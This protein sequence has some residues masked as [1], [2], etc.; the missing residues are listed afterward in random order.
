MN[1]LNK[2]I[3]QDIDENY[4]YKGEYSEIDSIKTI[5]IPSHPAEN[6]NLMVLDESGAVPFLMKRVFVVNAEEGSIRGQHAHKRC[7][8]LLSCL[9][10]SI[11]VLCDDGKDLIEFTL[12]PFEKALLIPAGIWGVQKYIKKDSLLMVLC[13]QSYNEGDYIRDYSE[14]RQWKQK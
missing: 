2:N 11:D 3:N 10:G 9:S 6:G 4:I 5:D 14:F 7:R 13:D 8:Q 1:M 12:T